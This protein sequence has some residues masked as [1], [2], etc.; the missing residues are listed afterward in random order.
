MKGSSTGQAFPKA[1]GLT[2][3]IGSGKTMVSRIFL[4][5]GIP[6]YYADDEAKR[7]M[8]EDPGLKEAITRIFGANAY[9]ESGLDRKLISSIV[10]KD[11]AKLAQ[12]N[13]I[14][15]PVTIRDAD[16]WRKKQVAP[17][18]IKEAALL[19]ESGANKSLD[20]IIAV[21]A[22]LE[23][24]I[25]RVITRDKL[26]REEVLRRMNSQMNEEKKMA[27]CDFVII[28]DEK[29][30]LIEQVLAVHKVLMEPISPFS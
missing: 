23:L 4:T 18:I 12:L 13:T 14:V 9:K 24:R 5:L 28:N 6:V 10:Y 8:N 19:F 1:I 15:H 20:K 30:S 2:G 3:G 17:Y 11:P 7:L 29:H 16:E 25:A 21:S 26:S 22:P 27:L